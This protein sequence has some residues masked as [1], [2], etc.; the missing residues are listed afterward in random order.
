MGSGTM[1]FKVT[2][3]CFQALVFLILALETAN[4]KS[5]RSEEYNKL[6]KYFPCF[7]YQS[8]QHRLL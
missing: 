2:G 7:F 1:K 3:E 5:Q 8:I 6:P 4:G